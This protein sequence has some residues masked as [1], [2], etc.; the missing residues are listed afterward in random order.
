MID[1]PVWQSILLMLPVVFAIALVSSCMRFTE[2]KTAAFESFRLTLF[3]ILGIAA[4]SALA[5]AVHYLFA[6]GVIWR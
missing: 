1:I 4:L 6:G 3:I 5:F 2:L